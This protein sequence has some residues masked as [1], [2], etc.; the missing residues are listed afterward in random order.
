MRTTVLTAVLRL[1]S[2]CSLTP[3]VSLKLEVCGGGACTRN[4]GALLLDAVAALS[5]KDD[6]IEVKSTAC[7]SKCPNRDVVLRAGDAQSTVS[8]NGL[9]SAV[10]TAA[11]WL[12]Q[13]GVPLSAALREGFVAKVE[14]ED[15][16]RSGE[17][18]RAADRFSAALDAAPAGLA[19]TA[20]HAPPEDEPLVWDESVWQQEALGGGG[21]LSFAESSF[22]YEYAA[23]GGAVLTNCELID[24]ETARLSLAL[25]LP[26]TLAPY[27]R[28]HARRSP[29]SPASPP[30]SLSPS[31]VP[32]PL[33]SPSPY[34]CA[35][36]SPTF[37][38]SLSLTRRG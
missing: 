4:G 23:C 27:A 11:E 15:A 20:A 5:C 1:L 38:L 34:P 30:P 36:R 19:S 12:E 37:T 26:L 17:A 14:G 31:P 24:E 29:A 25:A 7:M 3:A 18:Q 10:S 33:P 2:F 22:T 8:A 13:A 6:T 32:S 35:H 16:L 21:L 9:D 28:P